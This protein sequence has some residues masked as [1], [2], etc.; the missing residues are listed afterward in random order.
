MK[1]L[2]AESGLDPKIRQYINQY[3]Y[4]TKRYIIVAFRI[5]T[6]HTH[7]CRHASWLVR[8]VAPSRYKCIYI[9]VKPCI[10]SSSSWSRLR[11]RRWRDDESMRV[12]MH[13]LMRRGVVAATQK[14]TI[15]RRL[16]ADRFFFCFF[17]HLMRTQILSNMRRIASLNADRRR[18]RPKIVFAD[19]SVC[20][21]G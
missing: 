18:A 21:A 15:A 9:Y 14:P 10:W 11:F 7:T 12:Y 2:R 8:C 1:R 4:P 19:E 17:V 20:G 16:D 3:I 13:R 5:Q 6:S